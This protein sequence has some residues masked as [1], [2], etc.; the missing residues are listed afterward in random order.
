VKGHHHIFSKNTICFVR[1]QGG[2]KFLSAIEPWRINH[3]ACASPDKGNTLSIS[4][5]ALQHHFV[6]N[7]SLPR[8]SGKGRRF[9]KV[10][11]IFDPFCTTGV[12][13]Y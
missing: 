13:L 5:I 2:R 3:S 1:V 9:A 12:F 4:M 10:S 11:R 8:E 7:L 6:Q